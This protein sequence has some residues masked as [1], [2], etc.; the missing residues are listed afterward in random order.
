MFFGTTVSCDVLNSTYDYRRQCLDCTLRDP[1]HVEKSARDSV[2]PVSYTQRAS[3]TARHLRVR[4]LYLVTL[5]SV[6]SNVS[7]LIREH[8]G[9]QTR[10]VSENTTGCNRS[11]S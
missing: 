4:R 1:M 7:S 3:A 9:V 2:T 8:T 11:V 10:N 6:R 5:S